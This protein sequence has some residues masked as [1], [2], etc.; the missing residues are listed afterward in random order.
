MLYGLLF[1]L[2]VLTQR[3]PVVYVC[4]GSAAY[5]YYRTAR[6]EGLAWCTREVG[7]VPRAAAVKMGRRACGRC[8]PQ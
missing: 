5:A 2:S 8:R 1:L 7:A 6:C 3:E 4:H